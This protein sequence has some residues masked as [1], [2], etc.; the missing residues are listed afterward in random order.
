MVSDK[1]Q[2][3]EKKLPNI[4]EILQ[5][6][7]EDFHYDREDEGCFYSPVAY[8]KAI[9]KIIKLFKKELR[10]ELLKEAEK[11]K[12]SVATKIWITDTIDN[13]LKVKSYKNH[14]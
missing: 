12:L 14:E 13:Y 6:I 5:D 1:V 7:L 11:D 4:I 10:K 3:K 9:T 8:P 2:R